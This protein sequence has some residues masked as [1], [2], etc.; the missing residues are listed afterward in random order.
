MKNFNYNLAKEIIETF[1]K[2]DN[3]RDAA[4]GMQEDWFWSGCSIWSNGK[5]T[6]DL[7]ENDAADAMHNEFVKAIKA[8]ASIFD[9]GIKKFDPCFVNGLYGSEWATP[10]VQ[11]IMEDGNVK[12]FECYT[13]ESSEDVLTKVRMEMDCISNSGVLSGP[14]NDAR[15]K[16]KV[17]IFE[18]K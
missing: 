1:L 7:M 18:N 9:D 11:I 5:Y 17:E 4:L 12:V 15:S 6:Q 10:V 2:F 16:V 3:I 14:V 8:G 13:G